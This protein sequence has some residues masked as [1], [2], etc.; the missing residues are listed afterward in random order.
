MSGNVSDRKRLI[1]INRANIKY[2]HIY[3]GS[4][5][6]FFPDESYGESNKAKGLGEML[7]IHADGIANPVLTDLAER[8]NNRFIF[9]KRSW[10]GDFFDK[11]QTKDG[12]V[13]AIER[14]AKFK[15]RVYPFDSKNMRSGNAIPKHWPKLVSSK[16][17]AIDLFAGCGGFSLGLHKAGFQTDLAVEWDASC[18]ETF[19]ENL[20]PRILNCAIQEIESFPECDIL[21]GGPPCQGFSNLGE[22]VPNDPRRQLWR[23]FVRAV[24]DSKPLIFILENVPPILKS[25]EGAEIIKATEQMGYKVEA[26]I[27]NSA[28]YGAPQQRKRA[29]IIGSLIGDPVFPEPT[30]CDPNAAKNSSLP[31]WLTVQDAIGDLPPNPTEENWHIGRNPTA[32]SLERY[33]A[34]P[35]GGNRFDLPKRLLPPCWIRKTKGG[36]DLMGRLWWDRPSVTI[37]TEFYKPE[38][39]RYLH[40]EED[41]PITHREAARLQG[42]VDDFL[43][44]GKRISVG[45]Q[46]GNAVPPP[47]AYQLGKVAYKEIKKY[48]AR[49][50]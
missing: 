22:R 39:G 3:L 18:C 11:H 8:G 35:P 34:V 45:I 2:K 41:R 21:V 13:V 25:A 7:T 46:I 47:L 33:K 37:R 26:R 17:T 15:Y 50:K 30:H 28:F 23:H 36:T 29:V 9:R 4:H 27:L 44:K 48:K 49:N 38:K 32:L 1:S 40:P 16:P 19:A 42:F 20:S 10:L 24:G 14:L 6:D 5:N 12:D 43:F 31:T